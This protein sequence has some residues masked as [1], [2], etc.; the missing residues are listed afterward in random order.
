MDPGVG[1]PMVTPVKVIVYAPATGP[2]V[3]A[4]TD[5]VLLPTDVEVPKRAP[6]AAVGAAAAKKPLG[7]VMMTEP[8]GRG[9]ARVN[10]TVTVLAVAAATRSAAAMFIDT[11]LTWPPS[12]GT[13]LTELMLRMSL[14]VS[15][16]NEEVQGTAN[17][18]GPMAAVKVRVC[19]TA[20]GPVVAIATTQELALPEVD[21]VAHKAPPETAGVL[22]A[23][24]KPTGQVMVTEPTGM[25]VASK[26][27]T[28][29]DAL[30][31]GTLLPPVIVAA[32]TWPPMTPPVAPTDI[33]STLD[34]TVRPVGC[35]TCFVPVTVVAKDMVTMFAV[36]PVLA[37]IPV[38]TNVSI[39]CGTV[40]E[41][42]K[43]GAAAA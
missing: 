42:E 12:A 33:M 16:Q 27:L 41:Y 28:T 34:C 25:A 37:G 36:A 30:A 1:A 18:L 21:A 31:P 10:E 14:V 24:N 11:A 23:A 38:P 22:E 7:H 20:R 19:V 8:V 29:T 35:T 39:I 5:Q 15:T 3:A 26:K 2:V 4:A 43:V 13:E 9:V 6:P 17:G 40:P 32:V